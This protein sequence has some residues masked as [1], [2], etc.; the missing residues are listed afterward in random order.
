MRVLVGRAK[1]VAVM[2]VYQDKSIRNYISL[3]KLQESG[4]PPQ[5]G[6]LMNK[7]S[8][9]HLYTKLVAQH[10]QSLLR[11]LTFSSSLNADCVYRSCLN[12]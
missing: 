5:P 7:Y 4:E 8:S 10:H 1:F 12:D 9:H 6:G 11:K 3:N 2:R